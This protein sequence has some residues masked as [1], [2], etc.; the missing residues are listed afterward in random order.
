M[1]RNVYS[2]K[3]SLKK[4]LKFFWTITSGIWRSIASYMGRAA[5]RWQRVNERLAAA[6]LIADGQARA[7]RREAM[8]IVAVVGKASIHPLRCAAG[9][10]QAIDPAAGI[11]E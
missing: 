7:I 10:R 4:R 1:E 6:R 11:E 3:S 8:I 2:G 5:N 9:H